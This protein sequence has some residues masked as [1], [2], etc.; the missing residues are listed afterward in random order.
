MSVQ[1]APVAEKLPALAAFEFSL[2]RIEQLLVSGKGL[3]LVTFKTLI[4]L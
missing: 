1:A 3:N 4:R 2:L